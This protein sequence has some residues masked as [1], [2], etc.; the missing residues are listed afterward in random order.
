MAK[1]ICSVL[2]FFVVLLFGVFFVSKV[3]HLKQDL[4][5]EKLAWD[6]CLAQAPNSSSHLH[7]LVWTGD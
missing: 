4:I 2:G 5:N 1:N 7:I 6:H 3:A